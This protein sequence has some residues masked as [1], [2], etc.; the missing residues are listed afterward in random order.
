MKAIVMTELNLWLD[1]YDDIYSDFDSRHYQKRRVSEDFLYEVRTEIKYKEQKADVLILLLPAD[2]RDELSEKIITASLALFFKNQ[3]NINAVKCRK[4]LR[5]GLLLLVSGS[6][7]MLLNSWFSFRFPPS[8]W[9]QSF[10]I[11]MEP[12]GWFLL[13]A[14]LDFLFYEYSNV[15][16]ERNFYK[17]LSTMN[18]C[19]RSS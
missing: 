18:I 12:A 10:K 2:K 14:A 19:F 17:E 13:W 7:L 15:K 6:I 5:S 1:S 16:K 3:Y 8:F 11:L 4:K 9:L